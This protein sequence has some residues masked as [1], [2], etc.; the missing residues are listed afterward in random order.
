MID[1][2]SLPPEWFQREDERVDR[3]F[4]AQPRLLVH[5]DDAAIEA[6]RRYCGIWLPKEGVL[7]DTSPTTRWSSWARS[8]G[9]LER[10]PA[11]GVDESRLRSC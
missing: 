6:I 8:S 11:S 1:E 4:Y 5:I 7:L 3:L 10:C 9:W 2:P